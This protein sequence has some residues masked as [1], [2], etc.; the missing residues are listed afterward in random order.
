MIVVFVKV[1]LFLIVAYHIQVL[2]N[3]TVFT[4]SSKGKVLVN[5][6][7]SFHVHS[8]LQIFRIKDRK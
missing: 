1:L 6:Y 2:A 7:L 3:L 4:A 8:A 5:F